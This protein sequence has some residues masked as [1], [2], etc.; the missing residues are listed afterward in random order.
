MA[1]YVPVSV[2]LAQSSVTN[3]NQ[4]S[5]NN[6]YGNGWTAMY[7]ANKWYPGWSAYNYRWYNNYWWIYMK[8][9]GQYKTVYMGPNYTWHYDK[10]GYNW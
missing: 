4:G 6:W 10:A 5:T 1:S 7:W 3:Q 2:P 9:D 8:K